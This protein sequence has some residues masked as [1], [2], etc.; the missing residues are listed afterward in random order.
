[1]CICIYTSIYMRRSS[2]TRW[3]ILRSLYSSTRIRAV[4]CRATNMH[5][6]TYKQTDVYTHTHTVNTVMYIT[7]MICVFIRLR[8]H[9]E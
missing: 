1:M 5:R 4:L 8:L 7:S 9:I 2:K 6:A 3:L